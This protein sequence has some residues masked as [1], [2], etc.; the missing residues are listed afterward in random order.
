MDTTTTGV[1]GIR[2][3][4]VRADTT[5]NQFANLNVTRERPGRGMIPHSNLRAELND[6]RFQL[7]CRTQR[8]AEPSHPIAYGGRVCT[9]PKRTTAEQTAL[10]CKKK[11]LPS[12]E[13]K[14]RV[15]EKATKE[16]AALIKLQSASMLPRTPCGIRRIK[17]VK[18][19]RMLSILREIR[20][21]LI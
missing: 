21:L 15:H 20:N 4:G 3:I 8:P 19:S 18:R 13:Q 12:V 7:S 5:Q 1:V 16:T 14:V 2:P 6:L 10:K 9:T 11:N 17:I